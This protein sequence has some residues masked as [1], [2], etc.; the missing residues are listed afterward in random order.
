[1]HSDHA[2]LKFSSEFECGNLAKATL[3]GEREYE[4]VMCNDYN[5][6]GHTQWFYFR[7]L[8]AEAGVKYKFNI[9]N[10][11]KSG[12]LFNMGMRHTLNVGS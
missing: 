6:R 12:S 9:I 11:F 2:G 4:L 10:F 7:V 8:G 5:T 3:V 1:M